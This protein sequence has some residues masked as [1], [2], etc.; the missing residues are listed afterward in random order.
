MSSRL[1]TSAALCCLFLCCVD[2][3][4][5]QLFK[6]RAQRRGSSATKQIRNMNREER[7]RRYN[8]SPYNT[9]GAPITK[10]GARWIERKKIQDQRVASRTGQSADEVAR[11]RARRLEIFAAA[12]SGFGAGLS[13]AASSMD[14]SPTTTGADHSSPLKSNFSSRMNWSAYNRNYATNPAHAPAR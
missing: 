14:Y 3:S 8:D 12:V 11:K 10:I 9:S 4:E 6:K 7:N 5:A 1:I 2:T 13:G